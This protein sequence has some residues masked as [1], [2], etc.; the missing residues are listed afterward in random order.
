MKKIT[1][2]LAI[3]VIA[4]VGLFIVNTTTG[5]FSLTNG[6][7]FVIGYATPLT[8][9]ASSWGVPSQKGFEFGIAEINKSGGVNGKQIKVMY[10]DDKCDAK[11][12][13]NAF[14]KLINLDNA[15]IITGTMC[16][17]VAKAV[18]PL[19]EEN[20]I[21]YL[22]SGASEDSVPR[23]GEYVFRLWVSDA[24]EAKAIADYSIDNLKLKTFGVI[25]VEDHVASKSLKE[26]FI[27]TVKQNN[28]N[29]IVED[30]VLSASKSFSSAISKMTS[31]N[32]DAIYV[33]ATPEVLIQLINEIKITGY[34]GKILAYGAAMLSAGTI[35]KI[36]DKKNLYYPQ[37]KDIRETKFWKNYKEKTGEDADLLTALGYDSAM[38]VK[39]GLE[40][41]GE[42]TD[43]I[44]DLFKNRKNWQT[45]RG[46]YSFDQYGDIEEVPFEILSLEYSSYSFFLISFL[47]FLLIQKH[48]RS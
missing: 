11:E 2:F 25:Y 43:C 6:K 41:C 36:S 34:R 37:P 12:G 48:N 46:E 27:E 33:P 17:S 47:I 10:E 39:E 28:A 23:L 31:N 35:D 19:T 42:N 21:F 24:Y 26:R 40:K 45:T 9:D 5:L 14:T 22:A 3:L 32:P 4:I 7:E 8:G 20:K 13:L 44:K 29:V 30:S 1:I 16:S 15:K 38:F 18:I